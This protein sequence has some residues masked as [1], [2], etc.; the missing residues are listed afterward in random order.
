MFILFIA[1][2]LVCASAVGEDPTEQTIGDFVF[3]ADNDYMTAEITAW[4]GSGTTL[5]IPEY[6]ESYRVTR[7]SSDVFAG[8]GLKKVILPDNLLGSL[9]FDSITTVQCHADGTT[10]SRVREF[11]SPTEP[12]YIIENNENALIIVKYVG[13]A[14]EI[15][16]PSSIDGV[17]VKEIGSNAFSENGTLTNVA[18][19]AGITTIESAAFSRCWNLSSVTIPSGLIAIDYH[20]FNGCTKLTNIELPDSV[21]QIGS[22]AFCNTGIKEV[23]LPDNLSTVYSDSFEDKTKIY[24]HADGTTALQINDFV[25]PTAPDY[26]LKVYDNKV[27]IQNYI[28]NAAEVTIPASIDEVP[29]KEIAGGAFAENATITSVAIPVGVSTIGSGAFQ[30]CG[31]LASATIPSGVTTISSYLFNGCAKLTS[32]DIPDSVS[33]INGRAFTGTGLR[34]IILPDGI[35]YIE[36]GSS[37]F[38]YGPSFDETTTLQ[39]HANSITA[40]NLYR[41]FVSP[42]EPDY[43][44]LFFGEELTISGY[45]GSNAEVSIPASI[46]NIPVKGIYAS[47]FAGNGTIT[48]VKIPVGV[49][50]IYNYAFN[51]CWS[52]SS[53]S[54][55]EGIVLLDDYAFNGC[56]KLTEIDLPESVTTIGSCAFTGTGLKRI[57]LPEGISSVTSSAF[58]DTTTVECLANSKAASQLYSFVSPSAPDYVLRA[59]EDELDLKRYTGSAAEATIPSTIDGLPVT[60]IRSEAFKGN[61]T[62][63]SVTIPAGVTYIGASAFEECGK[64]ATVTIPAGV[65]EIDNY[66]FRKCSRLGTVEIPSSVTNIGSDA[67]PQENE[68]LVFEC[69]TAAYKWAVK[70]YYRDAEF[71]PEASYKYQVNHLDLKKDEAVDPTPTS[72]GLTEGKHCDYCKEVIIGQWTIPAVELH[73]A[74]FATKTATAGQEVKIIAETST[75]VEKLSMY[76]GSSLI[77]SW[78]EGYETEYTDNGEIKTWNLAYTFTGKGSKA[79]T[80]KA[81]GVSGE[82]TA[83]EKANITITAKPTITSVKF[84]KTKATVKQ[85]A[86]ITA[87]TS[88][89]ASTLNM[90]SGKTLAKSWT[91][92][93]TDSGSTRT[94]KV[95]F[96]FAGKGTRTMTFKVTDDNG[97]VSA[98]KKASITIT[99]A[100]TLTS[101]KFAK[102]KAT[103]KQNVTITAVTS[104][105]TTK[106]NMYSGST[107]AK[108]WTEGYTD[109]GT[110]RTWKVTY[111]F[112]G[113][114]SRT[115]SFKAV[116]ANGYATAAKKASI[117]ITA[118]PTLSSVKFSSASAKVK[119]DV[120]ITAVTSTNVTKLSM[121][122]GSSLVK[123]WTTGYTDK[124]T[125]RTW[126]VKYAFTAKGS[127]TLTFKAFDANGAAATAKK[128]SISITAG[129]T[130]TSVKFSSTTATV[131]Q[132]LTITAVTTTDATKLTMYSG[133]KAIKSWTNGYT[134]K[135]TTRTWK[136]TYSFSGTGNKTMTFKA[137][138][139]SG[140]VSAAKKAT[141]EVSQP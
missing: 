26:V 127:K 28:G 131:K 10:A 46:D 85:N 24:C 93:Y 84:A 3:T 34:K 132:K 2:L 100:P 52:L 120:T 98:E 135:G 13:S 115:M 99:A 73:N 62:V 22:E 54:L 108:S 130:L 4:N 41:S 9:Y 129:P 110:K 112:A 5:T 105:N 104:T 60:K 123:A 111:A 59:L 87:V 136:M 74:A 95:T 72:T 71:Y 92:G 126:K 113:K 31:N 47:A 8:R 1:L 139:S 80:F 96:A 88:T 76:S 103:V 109:N 117:T 30:S 94:W 101:V 69:N 57:V 12:D 45:I 79:M 91:S 106:L 40:S 64:L 55:P 27:T 116:D 16:I 36:S 137:F 138:N 66:A 14:S 20:A 11:V 17:A 90:Y 141:V 114:G 128:V 63:T 124:G 15:T 102:T 140:T 81:S 19:S 107:L 78:T 23:V 50:S 35:T 43:S 25:S 134:D 83:G 49:T 122:N 44:L 97:V 7:V 118:A 67:F 68:T 65:T 121:Y 70:N 125:T 77:K 48:S 38:S 133:S 21:A 58:D 75:S 6:L 53:V 32:V 37:W 82:E 61:A 51:Q 89:T 33:T 18:I 86:T 56:S 119:Q 39:C 29:V 42:T